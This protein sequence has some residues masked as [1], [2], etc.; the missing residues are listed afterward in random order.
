M[1]SLATSSL[2]RSALRGF[3]IKLQQHYFTFDNI[4]NIVLLISNIGIRRKCSQHSD[5]PTK[6]AQFVTC[7]DVMDADLFVVEVESKMKVLGLLN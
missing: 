1:G 2:L 3:G 7:C 6:R 5:V 4:P